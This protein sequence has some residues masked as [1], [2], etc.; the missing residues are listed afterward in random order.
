[1]KNQKIINRIFRYLFTLLF[2]TYITLYFSM[3]TG[4]YEYEN[5][6]KTKL[7]EEK[8]KEFERDVESGKDIRVEDYL[9]EMTHDYNN[10]FSKVGKNISMKVSST[11]KSGIE[12]LFGQL[13]KIVEE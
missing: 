4:Y 5:K 7:T 13:N 12:E 3:Q 1:M 9:E 6:Q 11:V 8:I 10:F 2:I